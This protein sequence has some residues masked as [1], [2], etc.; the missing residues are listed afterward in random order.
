M[1][2]STNALLHILS[3]LLNFMSDRQTNRLTNIATYRVAIA[4]KKIE[5]VD[6][7]QRSNKI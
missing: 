3:L 1:K 6:L 5:R 4:A 7:L 2:L